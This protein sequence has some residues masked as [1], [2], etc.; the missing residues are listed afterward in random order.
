M[1]VMFMKSPG[2][3]NPQML[4]LICSFYKRLQILRLMLM[5]LKRHCMNST[6]SKEMT[7]YNQHA[8]HVYEINREEQPTNAIAD[9]Q[10]LQEVRVAPT[11]TWKS[12]LSKKSTPAQR[13]FRAFD[14]N[15]GNVVAHGAKES[16]L[17]GKNIYYQERKT[18]KCRESW[19]AQESSQKQNGKEKAEEEKRQTLQ[20]VSGNC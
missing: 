19:L 11:A 17:R 15:K 18:N 1:H 16:E 2:K 13:I 12:S 4:L 7:P 8:H 9:L 3:S 14:D 5:S 20:S 10:L 6:S